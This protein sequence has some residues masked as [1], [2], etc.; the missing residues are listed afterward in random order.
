MSKAGISFE[1]VKDDLM[2]DDEF[3]EEYERLRPEYEAI[4]R[5]ITSEKERTLAQ[6]EFPEMERMSEF[7]DFLQE[8]LMDEDFR[9]EYK[10]IQPELDVI[11]ANTEAKDIGQVTS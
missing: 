4:Q 7:Q 10:S 1:T 11:R 3:K 8:Q 9:R 6:T 2:T 5:I